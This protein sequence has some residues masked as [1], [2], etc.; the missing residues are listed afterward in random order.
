MC[1]Y[2]RCVLIQNIFTNLSILWG[3][4]FKMVHSIKFVTNKCDKKY[5]I[6]MISQLN[7]NFAG[8]RCGSFGVKAVQSCPD[9]GHFIILSFFFLFKVRFS[10]N[11]FSAAKKIFDM[12]ARLG[13]FWF[14]GVVLKRHFCCNFFYDEPSALT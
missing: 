2:L 13:L 4:K 11:I 14:V 8:S 6:I 5:S 7:C 10:P 9:I 12:P 3:I 1:A